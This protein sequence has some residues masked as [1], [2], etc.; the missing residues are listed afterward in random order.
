MN[1][2]RV[3]E[4][5]KLLTEI[6]ELESFLTEYMTDDQPPNTGIIGFSVTRKK[7]Q[8]VEF[9]EDGSILSH[10]GLHSTTMG[11]FS[12]LESMSQDLKQRKEEIIGATARIPAEL[13]YRIAQNILRVKRDE[14][15]TLTDGWRTV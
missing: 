9:D 11:I 7:K 4:V 1:K 6:E 10:K 2:T 15:T 5:Q 14:L 3:T 12:V 13:V 8:T